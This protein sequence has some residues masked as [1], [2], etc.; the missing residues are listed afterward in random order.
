M[1]TRFGCS[2]LVL[3]VLIDIDL[4]QVIKV[5]GDGTKLLPDMGRVMEFM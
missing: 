1:M 3:S 5:D 2:R 4:R